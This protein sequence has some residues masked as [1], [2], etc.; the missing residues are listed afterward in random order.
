MNAYD[1]AMAYDKLD[2]LRFRIASRKRPT[3]TARTVY[4]T[5][6]NQF[7]DIETGEIVFSGYDE[8]KKYRCWNLGI[9]NGELVADIFLDYLYSEK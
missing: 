4:L 9:I 5:Y 7:R 2:G 8:L 1:L 6:L 3:E